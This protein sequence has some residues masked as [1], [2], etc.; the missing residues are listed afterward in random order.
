MRLLL[1]SN[2][3]QTKIVVQDY[4]AYTNLLKLVSPEQASRVAFLLHVSICPS[5]QLP[6]SSA[7]ILTNSDQI[8]HLESIVSEV[9]TMHY[10]VGAITEMSSRLMDLAKYSNVSLYPN[11]TTEQVKRLYKEADFYLDI[12]HQNESCQRHV[13]PLK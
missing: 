12:N 6:K 5:E 7:Y 8:E 9:P 11:I 1:E 3:R 10:H 2:H 4:T 13:L